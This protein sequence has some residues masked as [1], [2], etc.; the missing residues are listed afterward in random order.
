MKRVLNI[1][2]TSYVPYGGLTT[3]AMN[4]YRNIDHSAF[5]IDFAST[6]ECPQILE[7]EL[8]ANNSRYYKLPN[9][10][11]SPLSYMKK[12]RN[13]CREY[14]AVHIHGNSATTVLELIP[15]RLAGVEKRIV[16]IHNTKCDHSFAH[17]LLY[18]L[19][20]LNMTDAIACSGAAGEWIFKDGNFIVLNNAIDLSKYS[21]NE[22][23]RRM[24]RK[25][26][27]ID[28][29]SLVVGHVG[30]IVEQKNHLFLIDVFKKITENNEK[31][32]LLLVGDGV[33]RNTVEEK[34]KTMNMENKV[35]FAGMHESAAKFLSA[36]DMIVFPSLWEGLPLSLLEAQAN[37]LPCIAS[38]VITSEVNM[39][40]GT[41]DFNFRGCLCM[42]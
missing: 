2:T 30:K 41:T 13:I 36:M 38:D 11:T 7:E 18:P 32:R 26:Y 42:G 3:V 37:G 33:M 14:D 25:K 10:T 9:R 23:S 39:G 17:R 31:A 6:N 20:K 40:G 28:M 16:H 35:I 4:Y 24:I 8:R 12:L 22:T 34:I 21:Y 1:I 5:Q 29:D 27:N 15:A 19:M